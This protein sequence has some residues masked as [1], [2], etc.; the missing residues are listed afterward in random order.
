[1]KYVVDNN[2]TS[3]HIEQIDKST[4]I[5]EDVETLEFPYTDIRS[6]NWYNNFKLPNVV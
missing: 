6:I 4:N 5:D 3:L 2:K 1:M